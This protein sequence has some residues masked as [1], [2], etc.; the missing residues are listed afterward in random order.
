[1]PC[2]SWRSRPM[3]PPAAPR[4][5]GRRP[6]RRLFFPPPP[7]GCRGPAFIFLFILT[8]LPGLI[9]SSSP[10][11]RHA[12]GVGGYALTNGRAH[13]TTELLSRTYSNRLGALEL[14]AK[15]QPGS[16]AVGNILMLPMKASA[17]QGG[18]VHSFA[19]P[20]ITRVI[21]QARLRRARSSRGPKQGPFPRARALPPC[22]G[23][24]ASRLDSPAGRCLDLWPHP[25]AWRQSR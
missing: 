8:C 21:H 22:G 17:A 25:R 1:M 7:E 12:V 23:T 6:R 2:P 3:G 5:G 10:R 18:N 16:V 20:D 15:G 14:C 19:H 11:L 4:L 13:R 9:V 24:T